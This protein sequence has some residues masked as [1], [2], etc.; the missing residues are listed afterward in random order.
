VR[1]LGVGMS[2]LADA[3][4]QDLFDPAPAPDAGRP[5]AEEEWAGGWY[6]G[7]DVVH[8]RLGRGWVERV[9]PDA[10]TVRFEGPDTPPGAAR[11]IPLPD[12]GLRPAAPP[13]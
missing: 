10:L 12:A 13:A 7:L 11:R 3:V 4:Q 2:G 5:P 8:D 9:E 6:P 1:L